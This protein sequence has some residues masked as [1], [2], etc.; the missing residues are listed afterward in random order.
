MVVKKSLD[1]FRYV[2]HLI[3]RNRKLVGKL[4]VDENAAVFVAGNSKNMPEA[5]REAFISA[6][7][8]YKGVD[9]SVAEKAFAKMDLDGR[10]QTETWS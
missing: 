5:V 1:F 4:L 7:A 10:Y 8:A 2:Q 9:D 3:A 6:F